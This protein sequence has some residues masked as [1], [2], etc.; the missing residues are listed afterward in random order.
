MFSAVFFVP[1]VILI[2]TNILIIKSVISYEN[3]EGDSA[4]SRPMLVTTKRFLSFSPRFEVK[5]MHAKRLI[6][7]FLD[8]I[9]IF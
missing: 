4:H 3:V 5:T 1:L 7:G 8:E 2:I 6:A 9:E